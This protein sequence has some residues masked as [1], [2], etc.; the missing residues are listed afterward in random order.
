MPSSNGI[1]SVNPRL[2]ELVDTADLKSAVVMAC[3]F[4]SSTGDQTR[5]YSK[6]FKNV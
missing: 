4:D 1:N 6:T 5:K 2:V 3:W